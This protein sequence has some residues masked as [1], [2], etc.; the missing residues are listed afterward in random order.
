MNTETESDVKKTSEK[1]WPVLKHWLAAFLVAGALLWLNDRF[2]FES[3]EITSSSMRPTLLPNERAYLQR[4]GVGPWRRFDVVVINSRVL[5]HRIVKR[6][7]GLPGDTVRLENGCHVFV[8]GEEYEHDNQGHPESYTVLEV[9]PTGEDHEIQLKTNPKIP[10]FE[11]RYGKTDLKLG[12]DEFYVLGDNRLASEDSR[13]F[14]VVKRNE[15]QGRLR[16]IWYSLDLKT[17]HFRWDRVG[18]AIQ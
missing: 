8:N 12:P 17:G 16:M 13:Y 7:I 5:K 2:I 14:G 4:L 15:L 11:T 10:T 18:T 6:I 3:V 9:A 1:F